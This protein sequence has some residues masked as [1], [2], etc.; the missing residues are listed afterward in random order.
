MNEKRKEALISY[1]EFNLVK[2]AEGF[3]KH[4]DPDAVGEMYDRLYGVLNDMEHV[5]D[6]EVK[7]NQSPLERGPVDRP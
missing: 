4:V 3:E 5:L 6:T 2:F 1:L 7:I